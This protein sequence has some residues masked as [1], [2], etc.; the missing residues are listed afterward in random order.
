VKCFSFI[1]GGL[2]PYIDMRD[3]RWCQNFKNPAKVDRAALQLYV[4]SAWESDE[5]VR[6]IRF[7]TNKESLL[8]G[9]A[10]LSSGDTVS[11]IIPE[12]TVAIALPVCGHT[13]AIG[14]DDWSMP[15]TFNRTQKI[16]LCFKDH[17]FLTTD[18]GRYII[19]TDGSPTIVNSVEILSEPTDGVIWEF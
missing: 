11:S 15:I 12:G 17:T 3:F 2:V 4:D 7:H 19:N 10:Y 1:D 9:I 8:Y 6:G 14:T 18:D 5:I 13:S 16:C